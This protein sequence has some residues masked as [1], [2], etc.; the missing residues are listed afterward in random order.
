[1]VN[2]VL[3]A[4]FGQRLGELVN[5]VPS[6]RLEDPKRLETEDVGHVELGDQMLG[7]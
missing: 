7:G 5:P 3:V 2:E 6:G 1:V 4:R